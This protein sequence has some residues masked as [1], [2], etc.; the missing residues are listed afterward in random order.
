VIFLPFIGI[1]LFLHALFGKAMKPFAARGLEKAPARV[2][3]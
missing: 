1:A 2:T 3:R